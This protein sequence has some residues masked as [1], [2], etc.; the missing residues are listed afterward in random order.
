MPSTPCP[1]YVSRNAVIQYQA[2]G[3]P[4]DFDDASDA[5]IEYAAET[6]RRYQESPDRKPGVTRTGAYRYRG[7]G[8][9]RLQLIVSMEV[10]AEGDKPQL[11]DVVASSEAGR[12]GS[13][14]GSIERRRAKRREQRASTSK[15]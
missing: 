5:L 6:W 1:W 15:P 2:L 3:G 8:P 13:G 14:R 11:V 4:P 12:S 7:P 10:R 9:L